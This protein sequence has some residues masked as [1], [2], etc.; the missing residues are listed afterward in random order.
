[1]GYR[2]ILRG[3]YVDGL[4]KLQLSR[5]RVQDSRSTPKN[6]TPPYAGDRFY[7]ALGTH[8]TELESRL[9]AGSPGF[10]YFRSG[11]ATFTRKPTPP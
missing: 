8:K 11:L 2:D 6:W 3:F 5:G 1:M 4:N 10:Q 7:M 9:E